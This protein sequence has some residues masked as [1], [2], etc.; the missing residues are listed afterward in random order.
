MRKSSVMF[1]IA[2][3]LVS[4]ITPT[5][6]Q[7][8]QE[9]EKM[10]VSECTCPKNT[11]FE[12]GENPD[13]I[14]QVG[15]KQ[16]A[17]RGHI[18]NGVYSEFIVYDCESRTILTTKNAIKNWSVDTKGDK[19]VLGEYYEFGGDRF[20][21]ATETIEFK[22][23]ELSIDRDINEGEIIQFANNYKDKKPNIN[24]L[25]TTVTQLFWA[26]IRGEEPAKE[27]FKNAEKNLGLDGVSLELFNDL[28]KKF[29]EFFD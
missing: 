7:Q 8:K 14:F 3:L 24:D 13:T 29:E 9:K 15:D 5:S 10:S 20:I 25:E 22:D 17:L 23:N 4:L 19:L 11:F 21:W 16:F 1:V 26:S 2:F 6:C 18:E 28:S 27:R 12:I